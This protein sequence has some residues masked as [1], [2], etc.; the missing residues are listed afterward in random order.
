MEM[1]AT[2]TF[3]QET[4]SELIL[5]KANKS[6]FM[7]DGDVEWNE[8]GIAVAH[9]RPMTSEEKREHHIDDR[10]LD[11]VVFA[12]LQGIMDQVVDVVRDE[13]ERT[14]DALD[15]SVMEW[16]EPFRSTVN[17]IESVVTSPSRMSELAQRAW[18]IEAGSVPTGPPLK[19]R[20]EELGVEAAEQIAEED[21][22][23]EEVKRQARFSRLRAEMENE[24]EVTDDRTRL[25]GESEEFP[26]DMRVT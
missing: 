5:A 17:R 11:E 24:Q 7:I 25:K 19:S 3:T 13:H 23:E 6:G 12:Q 1:K 16:L 10:P 22:S 15:T 26:D 9:V 8:D 4:L 2:L 14:K 21:L 20:V 18:G